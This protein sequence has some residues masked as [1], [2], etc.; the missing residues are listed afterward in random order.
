ME[1]HSGPEE[2]WRVLYTQRDKTDGKT[3]SL[4]QNN[5][6]KCYQSLSVQRTTI[7]SNTSSPS[8]VVRRTCGYSRDGI[9]E[10]VA[11]MRYGGRRGWRRGVVKNG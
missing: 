6:T 7:I 2:R 5:R 9:I 10:V 1:I 3:T 8:L 11:R 4:S